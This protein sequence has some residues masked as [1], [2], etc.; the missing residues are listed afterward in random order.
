MI[1]KF[2]QNLFKTPKPVP[3]YCQ[4]S[5][6]C[7]DYVGCLCDEYMLYPDKHP[8]DVHLTHEEKQVVAGLRRQKGLI[9]KDEYFKR[10]G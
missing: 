9:S 5:K 8:W 3:R 7:G 2:L 4:D 6:W 10:L 1:I